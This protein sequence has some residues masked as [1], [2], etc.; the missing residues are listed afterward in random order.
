M[1]S[2]GGART[3]KSDIECLLCIYCE[4]SQKSQNAQV[5][6]DCNKTLKQNVSKWTSSFSSTYLFHN[7]LMQDHFRKEISEQLNSNTACPVCSFSH[8]NS[9]TLSPRK[10]AWH[11]ECQEE[12]AVD[13]YKSKISKLSPSLTELKNPTLARNKISTL[14]SSLTKIQNCISSR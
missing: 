13:M 10:I 1:H 5:T 2:Q 3:H 9:F 4:G 8:G 6:N 12:M 14:I 11:S 7:H